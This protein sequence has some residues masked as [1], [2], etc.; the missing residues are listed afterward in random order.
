MGRRAAL[1]YDYPEEGAFQYDY[2]DEEVQMDYPSANGAGAP[3]AMVDQEEEVRYM[4]GRRSAERRRQRLNKVQGGSRRTWSSGYSNP[5][6]GQMEQMHIELGS[7]GRPVNAEFELWQ[8]P[9]NSPV[10]T[11]VRGEDGSKNRVFASIGTGRSA[12]YS[13]TASIRNAGPMEFPINANVG[14]SSMPGGMGGPMVGAGVANGAPQDWQTIQGGGALKT[15][16]VPPHVGSVQVHFRSQGM[17]IYAK[18]DILQGPNS[19]RQGIDLYSDDGHSKPVSYLLEIPGYGST[20][21]IKN[22]GPV[23]YPITAS[24]VPYGPQSME[25]MYGGHDGSMRDQ[26]RSRYE[27]NMWG[28]QRR[29]S[30]GLGAYGAYSGQQDGFGG[31]GRQWG[32]TRWHE[33]P[34]MENQRRGPP[35]SFAE[36][37]MQESMY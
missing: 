13:N 28:G 30:V 31:N 21:C 8:G 5:S 3:L 23:E 20:I 15:F 24:V 14:M 4:P 25:N 34:T 33:T 16:T 26:R 22:T 27:E 6:P 18:I 19:D 35:L 12:S 17:P 36:A 2:P 29:G 1:E 32:Q 7:D 9:N 11:R 37:E 10:K